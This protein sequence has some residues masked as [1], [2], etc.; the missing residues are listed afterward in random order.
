M[1]S[2]FF[3]QKLGRHLALGRAPG[4]AGRRA[5]GGV[6]AG[7]GPQVHEGLWYH[8]SQHSLHRWGD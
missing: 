4:E 6:Y 8:L 1:D 3:L 5:D 7:A 2:G